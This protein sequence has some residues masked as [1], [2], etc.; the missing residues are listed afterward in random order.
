[1]WPEWLKSPSRSFSGF[2]TP[3]SSSPRSPH[4]RRFSCTSFK[5]IHTL[6]NEEEEEQQQQH[7]HSLNPP[8]TPKRSVFHRVRFS[9]SF[10]PSWTH[11]HRHCNQHPPAK[12]Q[13]FPPPPN[14][15]AHP[16]ILYFTTLRIVR[17]TYE[18]CRAVRSILR[19]LRVPVD[20]RDVSMDGDYLDELQGIVG[21]KKV[22][23]PM[24]FI[25][26]NYVGGAEEIKE[27]Q[28]SGALRKLVGSLPFAAEGGAAACEACGGLRFL[29]CEV[30]NG[31]HKIYME[32]CGFRT[33]TACNVNGLIRCPSCFPVIRRRA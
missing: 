21:S 13:P 15:D 18:D 22:T 17:R 2:S 6:V 14:S 27:M 24:V 32:K 1:M 4:P 23:L 9:T 28:E 7:L 3:S 12:K 30:C 31:S 16:I 8:T 11:Q 19:G 5:D 10:L 26:G 20:E 29:V 33:C 25:A